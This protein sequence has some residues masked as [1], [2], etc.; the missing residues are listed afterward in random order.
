MATS[1]ALGL[2]TPLADFLAARA[3]GS[4]VIP[5]TVQLSADL[6]T[7]LS[8]FLKVKKPG[9]LGFL[10]ESVEKGESTGR[11]SFL[12]FADQSER[13]IPPPGADPLEWLAKILPMESGEAL[14][15]LPRFWGG[16][17]GHLGWEA[18][19]TIEPAVGPRPTKFPPIDEPQHA[20]LKCKRCL[21]FDHVAQVI[22]GVVVVI[23]DQ[24]ADQQAAEAAYQQGLE[25][26][27]RL[28]ERASSSISMPVAEKPSDFQPEETFLTPRESFMEKV[29]AT[30]EYIRAG[31]IF[32]LVLSQQVRRKTWV[33]A[34]SIYRALRMLNP[35]P[36]TF[37]LDFADYQ[38]VGSSPEMLVQ[39]TGQR[40][41][42]CPIAGTRKRTGF[43]SVDKEAE[44]DML[45]DPKE[46]AEHL[47][48]VDLG[49]NDLGRVCEYGSVEVPRYSE[50]EYYS[51]V[52]HMVSRVEGR[53]RPD[54]TS[55]DLVRSAFPAGTVSGAP[56]IRAIQLI[57]QLEDHPR[58]FYA[59]A[60]GYFGNWGSLDTC[61]AIRTLMLKDGW[62]VMQAGAGIVADSDPAKEWDET[63]NKLAGIRQA[64]DMAEQSF[65]GQPL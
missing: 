52:M 9:E 34:V 65:G 35:S 2:V 31:D 53:L 19:R 10:L 40:A 16:A 39:L 38:L 49:R 22:T 11:Y 21:I 59:G 3:R 61:I 64:V 28:Q 12:G 47:M 8:L 36:Y 18:I 50:V 60:V 7:P 4:R 5:L 6:D 27:H 37:L 1:I 55:F 63:M 20:F 23:L 46:R 29:D 51:H 25:R 44:T 32:Q 13:L 48:L 33:D 54:K 58:G 43:D 45:N 57:D 30:K 26:L 15:D 24:D 14:G 56:K 62:A 42:V 17:V 41:V